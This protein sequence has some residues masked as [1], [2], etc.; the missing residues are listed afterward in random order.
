MATSVAESFEGDG[1]GQEH[2]DQIIENARQFVADGAGRRP[3]V[4]RNVGGV[5]IG[6][7]LTTDG[8]RQASAH[9]GYLTLRNI[10]PH[11]SY[12]SSIPRSENYLA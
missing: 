2:K 5:L 4:L 3:D 7:E 11:T 6:R 1:N 10:L 12:A 9:A 8:L